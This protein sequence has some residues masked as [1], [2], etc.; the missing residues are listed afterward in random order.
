MLKFL[1]SFAIVAA[2]LAGQQSLIDQGFN[3]FYN[4]EYDEAIADFEKASAQ[5]PTDPNLHNHMAQS[6]IF[7]EMFRDG[8]LESELVSGNNSFLRR[9]K[10]NPAPE[11]EK[12]ILEEIAKAMSLTDAALK[13]NPND[14]AA[15]YAQGI[16]FGLR[17]NYY[18]VVKKAWHD[19]LR[20]ATSARKLHN[21]IVELEPKNVDARLVQGLHDYIVGSLPWSYKMLGFLIGIK[22]DKEK[23]IRTVQD[24]AKNGRLNRVDAEIFL[25]ALY[26]RE[27]QAK[28]AVPLV[29]DL[30]QRYPR[31]YLLRLELGQMYSTSGDGVR[32]LQALEEVAR[33]KAAQTPGFDRL[34]WEKIYFQEG[35]IQFWYN[36]LDHS[37]EN[38]KKVTAK[39]DD[40]DLNT[41]VLAYLRMGQI[42][43]M[44]HRRSEAIE[45]YKKAIAYAP[46]ADAAQESKKYL[47]TPYRRM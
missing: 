10:L 43:D 36:D 13:K 38:M 25:C 31:N 1:A 5:T 11:T 30:I 39:A 9:A 24:V 47:S 35:S 28:L 20:D 45:S 37:L 14:T 16:A 2:T 44:K 18:W 40:V 34:P 19:S 42:Y 27:N 33:L 7:R 21:R 15:M 41:G 22:G 3:H 46:Q 23:G 4:L 26:R 12:R 29:Q 6:L 17:S 32:G 8:A